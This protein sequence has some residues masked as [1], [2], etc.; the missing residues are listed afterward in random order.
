MRNA[1]SGFLANAEHHR[2][3]VEMMFYPVWGEMAG[4]VYS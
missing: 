1:I 2:N 3:L 4:E